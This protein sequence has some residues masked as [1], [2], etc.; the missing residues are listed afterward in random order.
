MQ[1]STINATKAV[2]RHWSFFGN[3]AKVYLL[4]MP[5][6]LFMT[7]SKLSLIVSKLAEAF[8]EKTLLTPDCGANDGIIMMRRFYRWMQ[9]L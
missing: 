2:A 7:G 3:I 6:I 8:E 1:H 5:L 4:V 9:L